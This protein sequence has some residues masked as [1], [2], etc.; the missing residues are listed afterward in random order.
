MVQL[1]VIVPVFN[2]APFLHRCLESL[3]AQTLQSIGIIVVDDGSTDTSPQIMQHFAKMHPEKILIFSKKNG[4]LS[5]ARNFGLERATGK[6]IGFVDGDD[7]VSP[8]MFSDLFRRAEEYSADMALCGL[9][10][11]D[12][13]GKPGEALPQLLH[14]PP[15]VDLKKDFS[16]FGEMGYFACNKIFR[17]EL[18]AEKRFKNGVHFEDI[19]LIPQVLLLCDRVAISPELHYKYRIRPQSISRSH[20]R[21]GLDLLKAVEDVE[22]AF[23]NS[24]YASEQKALQNFQILQGVYSFLAYLAFVKEGETYRE[25]SAA[26]Q[27]FRKIRH[28]T[29]WKIVRYRRNQK[30]YL[31]S[32][33]LPKQVYYVLYFIGAED[34][35]RKLMR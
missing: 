32:L 19:Q 30:N 3:L 29:F 4:G 22:E 14:L 13:S 26:F 34:L 31:L 6:Y 5:D 18:F 35:L 28:L 9:Q 16:L 21:K 12:A 1:S 2:V 10:K 24:K 11:T 27:N 20:T 17:R 8:H 25:M 15:Q 7:E 33:P 23:R